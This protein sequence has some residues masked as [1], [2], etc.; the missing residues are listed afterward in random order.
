M[1][2]ICSVM[3]LMLILLICMKTAEFLPGEGDAEK[4]FL[5]GMNEESMMSLYRGR[6]SLGILCTDRFSVLDIYA[7]KRS[8]G[9]NN[10]GAGENSI[11]M[12]FRGDSRGTVTVTGNHARGISEVRIELDEKDK[13]NLD[14]LQGKLCEACMEKFERMQEACGKGLADVFL[15]D[16]KT[17]EVYSFSES[18]RFY[19]GD[20][21]VIVDV[22]EGKIELVVAHAPVIGHNLKRICGLV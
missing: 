19:V 4:C 7:E 18:R 20:Y 10:G 5:C 11:R 6:N 15:V 14:D 9:E 16:L 3:F 22:G 2:K 12:V 8:L 13:L 21:F 1:K 17:A